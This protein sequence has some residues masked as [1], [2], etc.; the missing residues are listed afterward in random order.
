MDTY[1]AADPNGKGDEQ[2]NTWR[3][4]FE[5]WDDITDVVA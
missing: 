1:D 5:R 4:I 2:E 3:L